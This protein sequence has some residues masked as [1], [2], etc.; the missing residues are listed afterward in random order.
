MNLDLRGSYCK[1]GHQD[2]T[3]LEVNLLLESHIYKVCIA[4]VAIFF[5]FLAYRAASARGP[6]LLFPFSNNLS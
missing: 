1:H 4:P 5:H 2:K 6:Q 3:G